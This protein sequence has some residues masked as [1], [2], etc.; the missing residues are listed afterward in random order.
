MPLRRALESTIA[1][2]L[3]SSGSLTSAPR[4]VAD[5]VPTK[6]QL[7][8]RGIRHE[9]A[10]IEPACQVSLFFPVAKP[11]ADPD[12]LRVRFHVAPPVKPLHLKHAQESIGNEDVRLLPCHKECFPLCGD[13]RKE[14]QQ[15]YVRCRADSRRQE[16]AGRSG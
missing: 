15:K 10:E 3:L 14:H 8:C 16:R 7:R 9:D 11:G 12:F 1:L 2:P 4:S 6:L 5:C 13:T